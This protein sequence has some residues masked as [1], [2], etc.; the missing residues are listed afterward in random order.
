VLQ[1][2]KPARPADRSLINT[3]AVELF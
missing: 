1:A 2:H 3:G